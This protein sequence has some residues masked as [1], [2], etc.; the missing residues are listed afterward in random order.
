MPVNDSHQPWQAS[1]QLL[2]SIA[3]QYGTPTYIYHA[4]RIRERY[5][6]YLKNYPLHVHYAVKTNSNLSILK[7]LSDLGAGFDIVSGGELERVRQAGGCLQQVVFSG[8]GKTDEEIMAA[9]RA[10]ISCINIESPFEVELIDSLAKRIGTAARI[11]IRI[12]PDID[13]GTHAHISTGLKK[14]KFGIAIEELPALCREI[15]TKSNLHLSGLACHIGSQIS[16]LQPFSD[17]IDRMLETADLLKKEFDIALEHLDFGGGLGIVHPEED[18]VPTPRELVTLIGDKM[19]GRSEKVYIE[20][21]RSLIGNA[22]ILISRVIGVKEQNGRRFVLIDAGMN[23]YMRVAL[24]DAYPRIIR[25]NEEDLHRQ[26]L[27]S[28]VAGPVCESSDVFSRGDTDFQAQRG[29]LIALLGVGAYGFS[30]SSQ[31]NSRPRA[32][33]VLVEKDDFRLIRKRERYS[34]L[35]QHEIDLLE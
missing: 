23:D 3:E 31:Y 10:G 6:A 13:A 1:A 17:A 20:P 35:W 18:N 11:A 21:G 33:E 5:N 27:P 12:N 24:Y 9:L 26:A 4:D 2:Q 32:A 19:Q 34:D 22:G 30:M 14:N 15:L 8:V 28:S 7:L 16:K 25:M 29:E